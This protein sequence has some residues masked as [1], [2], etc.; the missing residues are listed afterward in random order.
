MKI[1]LSEY[2]NKVLGCWMGKNIGGTLGAPFEWLRQ[3]NDVHFYQQNLDGDP[4]PNDD[5]DIQL[6]WLIAM[7]EKGVD[8][9][10]NC[11]ENTGCFLSHLTG[12]NT[13]QSL[14]CAQAWSP[15]SGSYSNAY[16]DS[17]GA[18]IRSEIWACVAPR[19]PATAKFAFEDAIIDHGDGEGV[20]GN[21]LLHFKVL[22]L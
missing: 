9:D 5:L 13:M 15:L 1:S 6:I 21:F 10:A 3:I 20:C 8:I 4:L 12:L 17:C 18:F 22:H 19:Y 7:E 14:I 2:K 16:K 11:L